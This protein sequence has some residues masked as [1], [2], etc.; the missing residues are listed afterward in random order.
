MYSW[1]LIVTIPAL[2]QEE[3]ERHRIDVDC[4]RTDRTQPLFA[5]NQS[6]DT[7]LD[8]EKQQHQLYY[9]ISPTP[10]EVG[11][12]SPSNEHIDRLGS[13]LLTY[14]FYEKELGASFLRFLG[15]S[16]GSDSASKGMC[17]ACQTSARPC[18]LSLARTSH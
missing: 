2:R 13:I 14:N 8:P 18:M 12:Q 7:P 16:V 9:T 10:D 4:R 1:H 6:S 17:R 15:D 3:Q 5:N 11:A